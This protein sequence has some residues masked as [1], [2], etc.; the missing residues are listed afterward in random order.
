MSDV[1]EPR[2]RSREHNSERSI[3]RTEL[4]A[5]G[6]NSHGAGVVLEIKLLVGAGRRA[7]NVV[8]V[9]STRNTCQDAFHEVGSQIRAQSRGQ[10]RPQRC[11]RAPKTETS[12]AMAA[13]GN[14]FP[15]WECCDSCGAAGCSVTAGVAVATGR[16]AGSSAICVSEAVVAAGI[17]V[18][19]VVAVVVVVAAVD[20]S[21]L[22]SGVSG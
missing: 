17:V 10:I 2:V 19:A 7:F 20:G 5:G 3:Q 4:C 8:V 15:W 1:V 16:C 18:V 14:L 12:F 13:S 22:I 6:D 9:V 21:V 11:Y